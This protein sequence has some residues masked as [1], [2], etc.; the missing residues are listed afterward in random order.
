M[1]SHAGFTAIDDLA[2]GFGG[3]YLPPVVPAPWPGA[4]R[5]ENSS[6]RH[7]SHVALP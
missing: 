4:F 1:I 6:C 5:Q 2:H 7:E 3:G